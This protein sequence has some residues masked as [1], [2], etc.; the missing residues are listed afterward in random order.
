MD[1]NLLESICAVILAA[2][3]GKRMGD[4]GEAN[5]V[6]VALKGEAIILR[7][8]RNLK[9]AGFKNILVVVGHAKNSVQ[10]LIGN[11]PIVEQ[12]KQLGTADAVKA[13]MAKIPPTTRYVLVL[14]G[15]DSY[16]WSRDILHKLVSK[17]IRERSSVTL[18]TTKLKNPY[19]AGRIIRDVSGKMSDIVEEKD[20]TS[21][22]RRIKEVNLGCF[23]FNKKF[24]SEYLPKIAKSKVSGEYY[25]VSLID[26]AARNGQKVDCLKLNN[27]KWRGI[28]SPDDLKEA[29]NLL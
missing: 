1:Q 9:D 26:I 3:K 20:A 19:G 10:D 14:N 24:L 28:N 17:H 4:I 7:A 5:K 8:L 27:F 2:G 22:Q 23:I 29:E 18:I 11:V 6:T 16:L 13:A 15:D 25:L 12:K 21:S